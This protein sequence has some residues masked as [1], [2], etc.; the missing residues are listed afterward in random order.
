[1]RR[2]ALPCFGG[3]KLEMLAD[4]FLTIRQTMKNDT[5]SSYGQ[6]LHGELQRLEEQQGW[7][8]TGKR[9]IIVSVVDTFRPKERKLRILDIGCGTGFIL[10]R[11]TSIGTVYGVDINPKAVKICWQRG[12]KYVTQGDILALPY[13]Q[14][15]F[16]IVILADI[17]EHIK[18]DQKA[19][20]EVYRVTKPGGIIVV[21]TPSQTIPW[22]SL[23]RQFGHVRRYNKD[24]LKKTMT[25]NG[26][27][28]KL[29]YTNFFLYIPILFIRNIQ[30]KRENVLGLDPTGMRLLPVPVEKLFSLLFSS[31]ALL[32][33]FFDLPIGV[34]LLAVA[35]KVS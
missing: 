27:I 31:E 16:D 7:W 21:H 1:M 6:H 18:D 33:K 14:N 4:C 19:I 34:S 32:L 35:Q 20:D 30:K 8:F 5:Y 10:E 3:K 11:L 25:K 9:T 29:S 17:I 23:D 26:K 12:L 28:L 2:F 24:R 15:Y 22:S 13:K